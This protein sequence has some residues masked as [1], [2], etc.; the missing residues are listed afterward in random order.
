MSAYKMMGVSAANKKK[1]G[2][3]TVVVRAPL[4]LI[5]ESSISVKPS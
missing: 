4:N 3:M 1:A 2:K 5:T